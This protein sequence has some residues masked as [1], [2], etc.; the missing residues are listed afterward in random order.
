MINTEKLRSGNLLFKKQALEIHKVTEKD[1]EDIASGKILEG[2]FEFLTLSGAWFARMGFRATGKKIAHHNHTAF[3]YEI[4]PGIF[5][6]ENQQKE[7]EIYDAGH[8][9]IATM[10]HVHDMQNAWY[11]LTGSELQHK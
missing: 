6:M 3:E 4:Y 7:F 10:K 8:N 2:A 5:I 11:N 1:I 9:V